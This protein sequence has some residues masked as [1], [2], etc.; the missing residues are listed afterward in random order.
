MGRDGE[1]EGNRGG[2]INS[3]LCP[4][5]AQ[6]RGETTPIPD[7]WKSCKH[8]LL[9]VPKKGYRA[10]SGVSTWDFES[11]VSLDG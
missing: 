6:L 4:L 7:A 5:L 8:V 9:M 3:T 1:K 11:Y 10:D 2:E